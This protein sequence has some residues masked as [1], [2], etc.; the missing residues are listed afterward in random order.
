MDNV[1]LMSAGGPRAEEE[2]NLVLQLFQDLVSS[3]FDGGVNRCVVR[4]D[5]RAECL[6]LDPDD[7]SLDPPSPPCSGLIVGMHGS[8]AGLVLVLV[9]LWV[10]T[11]FNGHVLT[12]T[13]ISLCL[14]GTTGWCVLASSP[15]LG[16]PTPP[17]R[18][19]SG[20]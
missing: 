7:G 12:L 5:P 16:L 18:P 14:W 19:C 11:D 4:R 15:A 9:G 2:G 6:L 10:L 1:I 20:R 3:I 8:F 13:A 17:E